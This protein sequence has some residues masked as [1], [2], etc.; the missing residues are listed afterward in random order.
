M[1]SVVTPVY[2]TDE[3]WLAKCIES[4]RA[5]IYPHWELCLVNDGSTRPHVKAILDEYARAEPRIRVE[6]LPRNPGH[7]GRLGHGLELASGD[8]VALLD[9]D[10]ELAPEALFEVVKRLND[11]PELDLIYTDEDKLEM[12]GRRIEPFFK[13]D[14]S[15]DLLLVDELH[16]PPVGVP[17]E[18]PVERS[19]A[20]GTG[21]T[22]ARTTTS[23]SASPSAPSVSP[24]SPRCSTTG[25]RSPAP[26]AASSAAKPH[27]YEAAR[28]ALEE[29]LAAPR[30]RG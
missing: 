4:V 13:P 12:D 1:I 2:N 17:P 16:H 5:Q 28:Q 25:A 20:S 6:H 8:F 24:T 19:A 10:D 26:S 11:D 3:V 18:P 14:W 9:H 30:L 22:A 27:A 29:S 15:P 23:S 7:R 21:S